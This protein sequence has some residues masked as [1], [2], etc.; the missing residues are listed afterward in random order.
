M[1]SAT[2]GLPT[3]KRAAAAGILSRTDL[4]NVTSRLETGSA[5]GTSGGDRGGGWDWGS[6]CNG[7]RRLRRCAPGQCQEGAEGC[8][9]K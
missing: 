2:W 8:S 1:T 9:E 7:R 6:G 5:R 3:D 4:P